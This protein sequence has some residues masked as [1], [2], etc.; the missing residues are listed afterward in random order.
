LR[1]IGLF[2]SISDIVQVL[3]TTVVAVPFITMAF[4]INDIVEKFKKVFRRQPKQKQMYRADSAG[5]SY[6]SELIVGDGELES[7]GISLRWKYIRARGRKSN[8][9]LP[10]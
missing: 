8:G 5:N 10:V 7:K 6:S 1:T 4:L 3:F 2:Y 9:N